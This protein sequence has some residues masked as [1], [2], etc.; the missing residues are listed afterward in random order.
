MNNCLALYVEVVSAAQQVWIVDLV[1][2][3]IRLIPLVVMRLIN[4]TL[5]FML[6]FVSH[7]CS[8]WVHNTIVNLSWLWM[9]D[10]HALLLGLVIH[11]LIKLMLAS[12]LHM[13]DFWSVVWRQTACLM[14]H[15]NYIVV[16]SILGLLHVGV[17]GKCLTLLCLSIPYLDRSAVMCVENNVCF[18]IWL[19]VLVINPFHVWWNIVLLQV[20]FIFKDNYF[21]FVCR[22]MIRV[23]NR[24]IKWI[25]LVILDIFLLLEYVLHLSFLLHHLFHVFH[26]DSLLL[27]FLLSLV[28]L[29]DGLINSTPFLFQHLYLA[30]QVSEFKMTPCFWTLI[31]QPSFVVALASIFSVSVA[32]VEH[33]N[34]NEVS[35]FGVHFFAFTELERKILIFF[36]FVAWVGLFIEIIKLQFSRVVQNIRVYC[37]QTQLFSVVQNPVSWLVV[38]VNSWFGSLII[39]IFNLH[40]DVVVWVFMDLPHLRALVSDH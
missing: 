22:I 9:N 2:K 8:S 21:V 14:G 26:F 18:L 37:H 33:V 28:F 27:H 23:L 7:A 10:P 5:P 17:V 40:I 16:H 25:N 35:H 13:Q 6:D 32:V 1:I 15:H 20:S 3:V 38:F 36:L 19:F 12:F 11:L 34:T 30:L 29:S 4:L 31:V 24:I 39:T